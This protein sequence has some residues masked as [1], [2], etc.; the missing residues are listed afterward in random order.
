[1]N[2]TCHPH[3]PL[4]KHGGILTL[5]LHENA[6]ARDALDAYFQSHPAAAPWTGRVRLARDVD[7]LNDD[8]ALRDGDEVHLIPPVSG[9]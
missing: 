9:G 2:I 7:Y 4:L 8:D 5:T 6:T 3:G 1:M